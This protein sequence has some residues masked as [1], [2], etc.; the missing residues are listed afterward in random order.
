MPQ[1]EA[2]ADEHLLGQRAAARRDSHKLLVVTQQAEPSLASCGRSCNRLLFSTELIVYP[3]RCQ[4]G[5]HRKCSYEYYNSLFY[6]C[7]PL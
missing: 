3:I 2:V 5:V 4:H 6:H 7:L 1:E